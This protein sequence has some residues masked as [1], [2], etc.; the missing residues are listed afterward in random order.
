MACIFCYYIQFV[1]KPD[2][3]SNAVS[4]VV[5]GTDCCKIS[6]ALA[7]IISVAVCIV[8]FLTEGCI[9]GRWLYCGRSNAELAMFSDSTAEL[10]SVST[11]LF[12]KFLLPQF[13]F[14]Y[15]EKHS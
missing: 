3:V 2:A 12:H 4:N 15:N 9:T 6:A 8:V 14:S 10:V 1:D 13:L 11:K 5:T 7:C